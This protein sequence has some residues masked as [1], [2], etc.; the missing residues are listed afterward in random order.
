MRKDL[1][2]ER[3]AGCEGFERSEG[4]EG[5]QGLGFGTS[6]HQHQKAHSFCNSNSER[7]ER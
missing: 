7:S 1:R 5:V 6:T 4:I 2:F 3:F